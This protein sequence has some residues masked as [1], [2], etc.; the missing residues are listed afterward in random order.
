MNARLRTF[1][2]ECFQ[3]GKADLYGAF[4]LRNLA[5][6]VD[7]GAVGM[8]TIPNW[9]FLQSFSDLRQ[10]VLK[11]SSLDSLLHNGRGVWGGDF[12]SCSFTILKA[13]LE[14]RRGIFRRLYQKQG[15]IQTNE[16]IEAN[17]H[18]IK[19]YPAYAACALDFLKLP[20]HLIAYWLSPRV[21]ELLSGEDLTWL[22]QT[23]R[24][25]QP[26][27]VVTMVRG[28]WEVSADKTEL[29]AGTRSSARKSDKRWFKF[30][31]G[32]PFRK[33][34]GNNL[35][36]VDWEHNGERIKSGTN[37]IVP[38]EHL[39]FEPGFVWS[40][41]TSSVPSFRLHDGGVINGG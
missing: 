39:Y 11:D 7:G 3:E 1:L 22:G 32:G 5:L 33:W 2:A 21:R 37:P 41:V 15:E 14:K 34:Y 36:V 35:L 25:L 6:L 38:S 23:K 30:D 19:D 13:R 24:G 29:A 17:F 20:G 27:D 10:I 28:W 26:G 9:L 12:G 40:K 4:I 16:E 31:S 18:N 8:I